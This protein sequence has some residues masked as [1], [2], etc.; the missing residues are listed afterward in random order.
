MKS[1]DARRLDPVRHMLTPERSPAPE[2]WST[3]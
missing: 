2:K 3:Q 1:L